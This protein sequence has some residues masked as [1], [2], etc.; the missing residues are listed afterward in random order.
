MGHG[1]GSL[2]Q[3]VARETTV[4]RTRAT[5][6]PVAIITSVEDSTEASLLSG[7]CVPPIAWSGN[8]DSLLLGF[9]VFFCLF[10]Y[11]FLSFFL[12]IYLSLASFVRGFYF[13]FV[14]FGLRFLFVFVLICYYLLSLHSSSR[15]VKLQGPRGLCT[16]ARRMCG[17]HTLPYQ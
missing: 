5:C 7:L 1:K 3:L 12:Y 17:Q 11:L 16:S 10:F 13:A 9:F 8:C 6:Q 2:P 15:G 14:S 4:M